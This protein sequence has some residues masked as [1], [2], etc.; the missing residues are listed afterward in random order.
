MYNINHPVIPFPFHFF[1]RTFWDFSKQNLQKTSLHPF[2]SKNV[3][4]KSP[5]APNMVRKVREKVP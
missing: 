1:K 3:A 4:I 2:V 5:E